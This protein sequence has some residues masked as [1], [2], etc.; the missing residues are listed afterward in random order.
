[1]MSDDKRGVKICLKFVRKYYMAFGQKKLVATA[2]YRED[3]TALWGDEA[4]GQDTSKTGTGIK[5]ITE[6]L[7]TFSPN[8]ETEVQ[9]KIIDF[10]STINNGFILS[11]IGDII[12]FDQS[13]ER[14]FSQ[15]FFLLPITGT[16]P[17]YYIHND[18]FRYH[19]T[20]SATIEASDPVPKNEYSVINVD[21]NNIILPEKIGQ[22]EGKDEVKVSPEIPDTVIEIKERKEEVTIINK[23]KEN[24][25]ENN[26]A[27][28][29]PKQ[30][31]KKPTVSSPA[32]TVQKERPPSKISNSEPDKSHLAP[33]VLSW[34][35]R[36]K[37]PSSLDQPSF[38]TAPPQNINTTS[39]PPV[40]AV[41]AAS[42]PE[43]IVKTFVSN[44]NHTKSNFEKILDPNLSLFVRNIPYGTTEEN[45]IYLFKSLSSKLPPANQFT[46]TSVSLKSSG[47]A[48]V[49]FQSSN[50]SKKALA[51]A[52]DQPISISNQE[53]R[54]EERNL[55]PRGRGRGKRDDNNRKPPR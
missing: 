40:P 38:P 41:I 32:A 18:L 53:L 10:Q 4:G 42:P 28:P 39:V 30:A 9:I 12:L 49:E 37:S 13:I 1:M 27:G 45:I 33:Q 7:Q 17:R 43:T 25:A 22:V 34:A 5:A 19:Q 54:V 48:F 35:D 36:V 21:K 8:T 44:P 16:R 24:S 47:Y 26:V 50:D 23:T 14:R 52:Q 29:Q 55:A 15:C 51:A 6:I 46:V 20:K 3:S 2:F 31:N 11:V